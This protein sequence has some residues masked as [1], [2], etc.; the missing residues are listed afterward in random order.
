MARKRN[1][2]SIGFLI[3]WMIFWGAGMLIMAWTFGQAALRGEPQALLFLGL[4]LAGAGF[5]P[6][7]YT[8]LTLPTN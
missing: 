2:V 3:V 1:K 5:G 7:S 8:H 4:W 6:V